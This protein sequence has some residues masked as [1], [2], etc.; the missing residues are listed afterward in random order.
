[1]IRA[2]RL[3][4]KHFLHKILGFLSLF[5]KQSSYWISQNPSSKFPPHNS[6]FPNQLSSQD[7]ILVYFSQM[8]KNSPKIYELV[9]ISVTFFLTIPHQSHK[10]HFFLI[11]DFVSMIYPRD[12]LSSTLLAVKYFHWLTLPVYNHSSTQQ[13]PHFGPHLSI[14]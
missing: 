2:K 8:T 13:G 4:N 5:A 11:F 10:G 1:M 14:M 6:K 3:H 9:H 7:F 12:M